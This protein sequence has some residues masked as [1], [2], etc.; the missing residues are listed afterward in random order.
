MA[1]EGSLKSR[2]AISPLLSE[3]AWNQDLQTVQHYRKPEGICKYVCTF[4]NL[5][6]ILA[7]TYYII[8]ALIYACMYFFPETSFQ[9]SD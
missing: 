2:R 3:R 7:S 1:E 9:D 4:D 6:A 8:R 5:L